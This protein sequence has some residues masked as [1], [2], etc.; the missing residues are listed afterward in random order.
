MNGRYTVTLTADGSRCTCPDHELR[1]K[2]C[3]YIYAVEFVMKRETAPDGTVTETRGVRVTYAQ[4]WPAYNAAQT[5]EKEHF[6]RLLRDLCIGLPS[7]RRRGAGLGCHCR[8]CCS[9]RPS[10]STVPS[11]PGGS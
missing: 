8:T 4:N 2:P 10:R 3:K 5:T 1:Q 6:C 9:Q 7:P 11:A